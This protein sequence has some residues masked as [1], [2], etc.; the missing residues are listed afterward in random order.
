MAILEGSNDWE[1]PKEGFYC[2]DNVLFLY[3]DNGH[4][5]V[6]IHQ[7]VHKIFV[8]LYVCYTSMGKKG[9]GVWLKS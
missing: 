7:A 6:E 2:A 3:L 4:T 9:Q 5:S 8:L 1:G